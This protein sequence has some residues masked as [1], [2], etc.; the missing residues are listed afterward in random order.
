MSA[1]IEA[2]DKELGMVEKEPE[3][4]EAL[5]KRIFEL[6]DGNADGKIT[7]QEFKSTV[8]VDPYIKPGYKASEDVGVKVM[9]GGK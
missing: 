2:D 8:Y 4:H 5:V 9:G 6:E 7:W 3:E 1:Y